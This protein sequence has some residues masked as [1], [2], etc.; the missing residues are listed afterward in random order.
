M[1]EV[2]KPAAS[3]P[4]HSVMLDDELILNVCISDVRDS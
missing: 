1:A 4:V 2:F 3:D